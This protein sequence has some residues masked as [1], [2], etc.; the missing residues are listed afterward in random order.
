[1]FE[2][3]IKKVKFGRGFIFSFFQELLFSCSKTGAYFR[4]AIISMQSLN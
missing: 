1:M 3:N 4:M 2:I